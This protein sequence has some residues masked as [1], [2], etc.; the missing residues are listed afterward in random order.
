M[1]FTELS[2]KRLIPIVLII[3]LFLGCSAKGDTCAVKE[4]CSEHS[5]DN[6]IDSII[7]STDISNCYDAVCAFLSSHPDFSKKS[8]SVG[9]Y[10]L[11]GDDEETHLLWRDFGAFRVYSIPDNMQWALTC[12]NIVIYADDNKHLDTLLLKEHNGCLEDFCEV[13]GSDG[14][15]H[16]FLRTSL[17]V[18][19]QG[20]NLRETLSAFVLKNGRLVKEKSFH[21]K[22]GQY[23]HIELQCG[24]QRNCPL[25]YTNLKLIGLY[26][27]DD[28]QSL[29]MVVITI[30]NENDWPTG[31]GMKYVWKGSFFEYVGKCDYD[32]DGAE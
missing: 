20:A 14:Q 24:G 6:P 2:L 32:A 29:P 8:K 9:Y 21:T 17:F 16:Y 10:K 1:P 31:Y 3:L 18:V 22:N 30:V 27:F 23:D 7:Q 4:N 11:S 13:K 5:F 25:D 19:H 26:N 12:R 28:N 15:V